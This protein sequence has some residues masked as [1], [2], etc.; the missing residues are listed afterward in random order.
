MSATSRRPRL[1]RLAILAVAGATAL[2]VAAC[3]TSNKQNAAPSASPT[4]SSSA[5]AKGKK[6]VAGAIAS[7]SGSTIQVTQQTGSAT[8]D[9]TPSTKVTEVTPA[10]L[11]DVTAGNCVSVQ[12]TR[13]SAEA[14]GAITAQSVR[15]RPAVDGKC[16]QPKQPARGSATTAPSAPSPTTPVKNRIIEG[17]VASVAGDTITVTTT[18]AAQM[19][20]TVT[21]GTKYTKQATTDAQAIAQGKCITA[22]GTTGSGGALQATTIVVRPATDG[23]CPQPGEEHHGHGG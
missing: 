3:G 21:D 13:E 18:N 20:M 7:V 12:P 9:F 15:I 14:G 2:S 23:N 8:V 22:R 10:Q 6:Q 17:T 11:T 5:P 4:S 19:N 1:T 16:P